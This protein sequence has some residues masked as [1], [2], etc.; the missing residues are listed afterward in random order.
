MLGAPKGFAGTRLMVEVGVERHG[1]MRC[2]ASALGR[3]LCSTHRPAPSLH[4]LHLGCCPRIL[5]TE[6]L[7]NVT[8]LE[9][10]PRALP[11][12][13]L[14]C[15][16]PSASFFPPQHPGE[17]GAR[18]GGGLARGRWDLQRSAL[19]RVGPVPPSLFPPLHEPRS[20]LCGP[21]RRLGRHPVV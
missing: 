16:A 13:Q 7:E 14:P 17:W 9:R 5:H 11:G 2:K 4:S 1:E 15:Q 3:L 18:P 8:S 10:F 21:G 12:S 6:Q 19:H 20:Y